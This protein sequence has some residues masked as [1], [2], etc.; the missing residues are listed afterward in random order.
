MLGFIRGILI[1]KAVDSTQCVILAGRVGYE[2]VVPKHTFTMTM[3]EPV[4]LWLHSHVREDAFTLFGFSTETEKLLFRLLLSV[5]G[6]GPKTALA[7][8]TTHGKLLPNL[9]I[10]KNADGL[11]E[12]PGVGKKLAQKLV[13]ELSGKIEKLSWLKLLEPQS[14]ATP[15][16]FSD[17]N[18]QIR[19]DLVS[20]LVHLG[21]Q[22]NSIKTVVDRLMEKNDLKATRFEDFLRMAL[23]EMSGRQSARIPS[24]PEVT[25]NG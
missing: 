6:L 24:T 21:Y 16:V 10:Q 5:S 18:S 7:L 22:P 13:L 8:I 12:A 2:V 17:P 3:R 19:E 25:T 23:K 20:A 1:S 15:K 4:S 11:S 9:I 14:A